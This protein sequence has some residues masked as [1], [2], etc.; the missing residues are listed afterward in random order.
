MR[1]TSVPQSAKE[2]QPQLR[3]INIGPPPSVSDQDCGTV[4]AQVGSYRE[5]GVFDG[6][7]VVRTYWKPSEEELDYLQNHGGVIELC[8]FSDRMMVTSM[9]VEKGD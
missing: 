7:P 9:N 1:P 2:E 4:E 8:Y 3:V 5:V 6:A